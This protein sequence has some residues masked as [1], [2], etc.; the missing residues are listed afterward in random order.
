MA[1][2]SLTRTLPRSGRLPGLPGPES[3][4]SVEDVS[5]AAPS[6]L[7]AMFRRMASVAAGEMSFAITYLV[8][9]E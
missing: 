3:S 4:R 1:S 6:P 7:S 2:I 5:G 8:R 9:N